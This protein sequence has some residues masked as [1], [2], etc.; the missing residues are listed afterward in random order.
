VDFEFSAE[1]RA[2]EAE[3]EA[4]LA[5]GSTARGGRLFVACP[6]VSAP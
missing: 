2:F 5:A 4:F 6:T 1:E 3:V